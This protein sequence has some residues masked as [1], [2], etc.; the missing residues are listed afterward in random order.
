[1]K[2][3][4]FFDA[5]LNLFVLKVHKTNLLQAPRE[6]SETDSF[7]VSCPDPA[8]GETCTSDPPGAGGRDTR[9]RVWPHTE[10][11]DLPRLVRSDPEPLRL[12]QRH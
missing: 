9:V 7:R 12:R 5:Q 8:V 3:G 4:V 2:T 11:F 1:M 10:G 6:T